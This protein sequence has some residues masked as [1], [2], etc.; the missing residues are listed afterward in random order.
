MADSALPGL[1]RTARLPMLPRPMSHRPRPA[2]RAA[3]AATLVATAL[4]ASA[5]GHPATKA[6]CEEIVDKIVEIELR[7]QGIADPAKIEERKRDTRAAVG[8]EQVERCVGK[9]VRA[10]AMECVRKA[11][12]YEQIQDICLR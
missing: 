11:T 12:T 3:F 8:N 1:P 7:G 4:L 10:S 9:K 6:E 5:C 2:R